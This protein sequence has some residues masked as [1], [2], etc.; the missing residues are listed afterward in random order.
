MT[1]LQRQNKDLNIQISTLTEERN[2]IAQRSKQDLDELVRVREANKD[3]EAKLE[4]CLGRLKEY[5]RMKEDYEQQLKQL[6]QALDA[7]RR[8]S[9]AAKGDAEGRL[10]DE[11]DKFGK[12]F[13]DYE[14]KLD[15]ADKRWKDSQRKSEMA[16]EQIRM[17]RG[18]VDSEKKKSIAQ[19]KSFQDWQREAGD[20]KKGILGRLEEEKNA[21]KRQ[22]AQLK[23]YADKLQK[24]DGLIKEPARQSDVY[25]D[26]IRGLRGEIDKE[27]RKSSLLEEESARKIKALLDQN[28]GL[29][30]KLDEDQEKYSKASQAIKDYEGRFRDSEK[31]LQDEARKSELYNQKLNEVIGELEKERRLSMM[32]IREKQE[33]IKALE[34]KNAKL[35][36]QIDK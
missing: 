2:R 18:E 11:R 9:E 21:Q 27:R 4:G 17:L 16:D 8:K 24:S 10:K 14:G 19:E 15:A 25:E 36:N 33:V 26:E 20:E 1:Q 3:I 5:A 28:T 22:H 32:S 31:R 34:D 6:R 7:E 13:A 29:T 35:G 30:R 23:D 12:K